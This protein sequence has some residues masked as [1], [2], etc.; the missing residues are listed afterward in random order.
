MFDILHSQWF[1]YFLHL[2]ITYLPQSARGTAVI[3]DVCAGC[4]AN[5]TTR[6][7]LLRNQRMLSGCGCRLPI[8][9]HH[10]VLA[11]RRTA[12][13]SSGGYDSFYS[14]HSPHRH[15]YMLRSLRGRQQTAMEQMQINKNQ[16]TCYKKSEATQP[17]VNT[18]VTT[19]E[20]RWT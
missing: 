16:E 18:L 13:T 14:R 7:G 8:N 2:F 6:R 12:T 1:S 17:R 4:S 20:Q 5:S 11:L 15:C 10:A 3:D 19:D 9:G